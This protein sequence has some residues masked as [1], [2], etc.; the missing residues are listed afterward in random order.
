MI[1]LD[2]ARV[3]TKSAG[4]SLLVQGRQ[5]GDEWLAGAGSRY[6]RAEVSSL[7]HSGGI[8]HHSAGTMTGA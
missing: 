8:G 1:R 2:S 7:L 5:P 3:P 4:L 6:P